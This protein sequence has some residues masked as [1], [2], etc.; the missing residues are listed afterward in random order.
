MEG[1]H[2][3]C[4]SQQANILWATL[5]LGH[6]NQA[7]DQLVERLLVWQW[8]DGGWNCDKNAKACNS[9][10]MESI[11]PLRALALYA[12]QTGYSAAR[13]AADRAVE[14][15]LKRCL[16]QRQSD[17]SPIAIGFT[18]LHYPL[19]WH[20]DILHGLKVLAEAGYLAD[21]RCKPALDLLASKQLPD[22][23]W[24]AEKRYYKVLIWRTVA[25]TA[26][27]VA[28]DGVK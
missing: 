20:Y 4:A 22:G 13:A 21:E 2:R 23:G 25:S 18:E 3:R 9:S 24:P 17:G 11:L 8:P 6:R 15:F 19:Y 12:D 14:I 26:I 27:G 5:K 28:R 1:R 16:Y 7:C 10:Y